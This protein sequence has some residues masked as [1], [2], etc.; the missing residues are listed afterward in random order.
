MAGATSQDVEAV[1]LRALTTEEARYLQPL[2]DRAY[3][4]IERAVT[5]HGGTIDDIDTAV[6]QDVQADMVARVLRN[7]AGLR[8][9]S[10]GQYSYSLN[11][12]AASGRLELT[13]EDKTL[14]GITPPSWWVVTPQYGQGDDQ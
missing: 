11:T 4:L 13:S 1:L 5:D 7:P 9:E 10:D 14:L 12:S 3:R 6:I 8:S 2:L